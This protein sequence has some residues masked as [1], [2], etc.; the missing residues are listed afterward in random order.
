[1]ELTFI[2]KTL[3][4]LALGVLVGLERQKT[5]NKSEENAALFFG[6]VRTFSFIAIL[7]AVGTILN[8]YFSGILYVLGAAVL[9]LLFLSFYLVNQ[10]KSFLGLTTEFAALSTFVVGVLVGLGMYLVA[11]FLAV[12]NVALLFFRDEIHDFVKKIEGKEI[13]STIQF[14]IVAFIVLPLLP[15][16]GFGPEELFN[17]YQIWFLVVLISSISFVSY[18]AVKV[19]GSRKGFLLTGFL[20]GFISSTALTFSY[21]EESKK[22]NTLVMP[23]VTAIIIAS[24]AMFFRVLIEVFIFSKELF[25]LVLWPILAMGIVG[26]GFS[27]FYIY[28]HSRGTKKLPKEEFLDEIKSPF[29]LI[30]ALKFGAFFVFIMYLSNFAINYL[31][32]VGLYVTTIFSAILDVDAITLSI[33][34]LFEDGEIGQKVAV[35]SVFLASVVNTFSKGVIFLIFGKKKVALRILSIYLFVVLVGVGTLFFVI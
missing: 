14:I 18:I 23:I 17:P 32:D 5:I 6:G 19:F 8:Q 16:E 26:I 15:N 11:V 4:A 31:G 27:A 13:A 35:Y 29:N 22:S 9:G 1:M 20:A 10:K 33:T 30:P 34:S 3:L 7:G 12:V 2:L 28:R 24:S 21:S 25:M